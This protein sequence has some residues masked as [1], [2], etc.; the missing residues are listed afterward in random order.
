[1][2]RPKL[3][4]TKAMY[5]SDGYGHTLIRATP[6]QILTLLEGFY[7]LWDRMSGKCLIE[8]MSN[9]RLSNTRPSTEDIRAR[10]D[11]VAETRA[12]LMAQ[13]AVQM[14]AASSSKAV[15]S[16]VATLRAP[17]AALDAPLAEDTAL[18]HASE[19]PVALPEDTVQGIPA[20]AGKTSFAVAVAL[21]LVGMALF[22]P[23]P[24]PSQPGPAS[25]K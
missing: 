20:S 24:R 12:F 16:N 14:A 7:W 4:V 25:R 6:M 22:L 3:D 13:E 1:M 2:H 21:G 10:R 18:S 17:E 5:D 23:S 11:P 8:G 9:A 19:N 15:H